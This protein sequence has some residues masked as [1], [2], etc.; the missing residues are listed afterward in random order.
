MA[1]RPVYRT[2][3]DVFSKVKHALQDSVSLL[4]HLHVFIH[5]IKGTNDKN[6]IHHLI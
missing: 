5:L 6:F 1:A 2:F 3:K 4:S